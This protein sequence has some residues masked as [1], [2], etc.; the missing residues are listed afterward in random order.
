M[1]SS[2]NNLVR[3]GS[4]SC[5]QDGPPMLSI[6]TPV[7]DFVITMIWDIFTY[8]H[9]HLIH[10]WKGITLESIIWWHPTFIHNTNNGMGIT[11][12]FMII[13]LLNVASKVH[14]LLFFIKKDILKMNFTRIIS[15]FLE[16]WKLLMFILSHACVDVVVIQVMK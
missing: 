13:D 4:T 14:L 10:F 8:T 1:S 2:V 5:N 12:I 7:F 15:L 6:N 3:N 9:L 11:L 16:S